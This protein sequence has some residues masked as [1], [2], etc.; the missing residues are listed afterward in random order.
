MFMLVSFLGE[1]APRR[2][3]FHPEQP[4]GLPIRRFSAQGCSAFLSLSI[5]SPFTHSGK[6]FS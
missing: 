4:E 1:A 6:R 2:P 3:S 5:I